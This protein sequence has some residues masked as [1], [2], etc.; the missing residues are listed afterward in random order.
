MYKEASKID[1]LVKTA[2]SVLIIQPDNPDG[3]SLGSALALE[4]IFMEQGK[5][6]FL[7]CGIKLPSYLSYLPG[8]DRV[9]N[10]LPLSYDLAV[11]VDTSALSLLDSLTKDAALNRLRKKPLVIIDHHASEPSIDFANVR[12]CVPVAAA[13]AEVIY[14]L[15]EML[16][17]DL[18]PSAKNA[19]TAAILSDSLGLT[20]ENTTARTVHIIGNLVEGGVSLS[21]L[22]N[23][24]R[25]MMRKSPELVYYK[26]EL[27]KRIEY[28]LDDRLAILTIPWE[29][30]EKYSPLYNPS[31]LAL[32]DMR[33]T[34][35][36]RA[37]VVLKI[38][39]DGRI[40]GKIRSNYGSPIA[41]TLAEHLGGGGHDYASGFK[42]QD[43]RGL[44]EV[45]KEIIAKTKE[46]IDAAL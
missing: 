9:E 31:M 4:Q 3:D 28:Y 7:F 6:T 41:K 36:T 44:D 35:N 17:W 33:L 5:E 14:E 39:P 37:A 24:R 13:T 25:D 45:K 12:L 10:E 38:Y 23:S 21:A 8:W 1:E 2:H 40:T 43:S 22:E 19:L 11:V 34:T 15:S 18:N 26:G 20:T 27:L 16:K 42:L 29:E 32:D 46:L 30:I